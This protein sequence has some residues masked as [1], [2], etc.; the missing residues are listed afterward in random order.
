MLDHPPSYEPTTCDGCG[1][2]IVLSDAGYSMGAEGYLCSSCTAKK[3]EDL[4]G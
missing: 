2:V 3:D 1:E 4:L